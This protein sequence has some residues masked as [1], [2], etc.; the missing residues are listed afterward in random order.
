MV[1]KPVALDALVDSP[2][3]GVPAALPKR[4]VEE[5]P[6]WLANILACAPV[7]GGPAGVVEVPSN[8]KPVLTVVVGV[9]APSL[10]GAPNKL[11][12]V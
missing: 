6:G 7:G 10:V 3:L 5:V 9:E 1:K 8:E 11:G 12:R 4:D 2:I